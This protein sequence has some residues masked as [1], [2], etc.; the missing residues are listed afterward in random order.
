MLDVAQNM[1]DLGWFKNIEDAFLNAY[2]LQGTLSVEY[3][4]ELV[5]SGKYETLKDAMPEANDMALAEADNFVL[6]KKNNLIAMWEGICHGWATSAGIVAR[7]RKTIKFELPDGREMKFFPSDIKALASLSW[8]NSLIQDN[9]LIDEAT[10]ENIGGGVISQGLR[11]NL[12]SPKK[13]HW[14]RYYDNRADPFNGD[15]SPRCVGVHPAIWHLGLVNIIGK[16]G[17]S[18]I[19][20]RKV[21]AEVDNHPMAA[22][23]ME[24]FNPNNG[25]RYKD[26]NKNLERIDEDDQF[27]MLRSKEAKYIIGVQTEMVYIDW[28]RPNREFVDNERKDDLVDKKMY[29][30]LELDH[31]LNIVGGQWRAFKTGTGR[32][33]SNN[34]RATRGGNHNQ[35]DFFWVITKDWKDFFEDEENLEPWVDTTKAPPASWLAVA[36]EKYHEN[37]YYKTYEYGTGQKCRV[38]HKTT[39][40]MRV[41]P[42]EYVDPRPTPLINVV[43][44]LIE[45]AK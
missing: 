1:V 45:L 29:Y 6:E 14:G 42:C 38:F 2:Q 17:R 30:D 22:Y 39:G 41:V 9:K 4:L 43:N 12:D 32:S 15:H 24:Y 36:K 16:Q 35:P 3:A 8:A 25:R 26:I 18:F 10:G 20:E 13:D 44:K 40:Q 7:P 27:R 23:E 37:V 31:N 28:E 5:K 21:G 33:S 19:V 11:C 34:S